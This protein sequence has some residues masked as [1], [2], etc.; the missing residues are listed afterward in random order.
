MDT[1]ALIRHIRTYTITTQD[2]VSL[3]LHS[4]HAQSIDIDEGYSGIRIVVYLYVKYIEEEER[5]SGKEGE[6]EEGW[7]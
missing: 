3:S 1:W 2:V 7:R 6:D 5:G 4:F